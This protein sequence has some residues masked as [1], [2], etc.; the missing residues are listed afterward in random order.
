MTNDN[1]KLAWDMLKERYENKKL[2]VRKHVQALF[3]IS[4]V[5]KE[6]ALSLRN[7]LDS[8]LKNLRILK[9]LGQPTDQW[10]T[11]IIFMIANN[12]D[13]ITRR[14]WESTCKEFPTVDEIT[15]FIQHR[16]QILE[17][18]D[19]SDSSKSKTATATLHSAVYTSTE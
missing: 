3:D 1:Y 15:T 13:S 18:I 14:E 11:L 5:T 12:L 6:S 9:Q 8:T 4:K 2:I 19:S 7:L 17:S 10:D 16:C